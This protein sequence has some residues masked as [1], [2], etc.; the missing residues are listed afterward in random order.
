MNVE[1]KDIS[2]QQQEAEAVILTF[3]Q[4]IHRYNR[5]EAIIE[6]IVNYVTI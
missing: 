1:N 2:T 5:T 6:N 4:E 3:E